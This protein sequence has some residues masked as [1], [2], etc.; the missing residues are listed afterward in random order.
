MKVGEEG[1][2]KGV[3][4]VP[5]CNEGLRDARVRPRPRFLR[6]EIH[7]V[8]SHTLRHEPA[9][10]FDPETCAMRSGRRWRTAIGRI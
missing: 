7:T 3:R 6:W 2:G 5:P 9:L 10:A 1:E 4:R 8:V